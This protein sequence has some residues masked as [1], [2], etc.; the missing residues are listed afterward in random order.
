MQ[1]PENSLIRE[2]NLYNIVAYIAS[3]EFW[4]R[5]L[6][7]YSLRGF[8]APLPNFALANDLTHWVI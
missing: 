5:S 7:G 8:A 4:W 6:L 2:G 1:S 3:G